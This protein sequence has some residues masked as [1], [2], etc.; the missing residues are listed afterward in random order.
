MR[1][2]SPAAKNLEGISRRNSTVNRLLDRMLENAYEDHTQNVRADWP[3]IKQTI[4]TFLLT[5]LTLD[6]QTAGKAFTTD[7]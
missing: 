6:P 4:E 3:E 2:S 7:R 1:S 5:S